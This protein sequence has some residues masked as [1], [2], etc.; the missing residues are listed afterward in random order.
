VDGDIHEH[1]PVLTVIEGQSIT[2]SLDVDRTSPALEAEKPF[3]RLAVLFDAPDPTALEIATSADGSTWSDFAV[4]IVVFAEEGAHVANLD[5]VEPAK[6]YKY[7]I[8]D[9]A[10]A[11][12]FVAFSPI[13]II[14]IAEEG[15]VADIID[16]EEAE[17]LAQAQPL[18]EQFEGF[19]STGS[20]ISTRIG[21]VTV[22]GRDEWNARAP[23]C[24]SS[25]TPNRV[26]IHHTVTPTNDSLSPQARL[27]Q[28]QSFHMNSNGWCDIGYNFLVSRDGRLWRG[29]GS[30]RLGAHVANNNTG[31]VGIS[32]MG[33]H[34]S[35][36]ITNRQMCNT[37]KLLA[38]LDVHRPAIALNRS[39]IKGHRQYGDTACPGTALYNQLDR[40]V[41]WSRNGCP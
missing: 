32:F 27:R 11:P 41:R 36:T 29:R 13:E 8:R 2:D 38:W 5:L 24:V 1:E 17:L 31:N 23:R 12:T 18:P 30:T 26:T 22:H 19:G 9:L 40:L 28:I 4:P 33:T 20:G 34:T 6:F 16:D 35:V 10:I 21:N 7:R 3:E 15:E 39:D 37:A 25:M 14:P